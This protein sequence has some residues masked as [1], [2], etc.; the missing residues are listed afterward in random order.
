MCIDTIQLHETLTLS[1]LQWKLLEYLRSYDEN[2]YT[3]SMRVFR[4][5]EQL[6]PYL[7]VTPVNFKTFCTAALFHDIGKAYIPLEILN[8]PRRLTPE[9]RFLIQ[10]HSLLGATTLNLYDFPA[11]VCNLVLL[12]HE[13]LDGTG[14]PY[15]LLANG[16]PYPARVLTVLDVFDALSSERVYRPAM[17]P[18]DA[19]SVMYTDMRYKLDNSVLDALSLIFDCK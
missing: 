15:H 17:L 12:H 16:I 8:A 19:L 11:T 3:H 14:Y 5:A 7:E 6:Y 2:T 9:E 13:L 10:R 1:E 18:C 4:L